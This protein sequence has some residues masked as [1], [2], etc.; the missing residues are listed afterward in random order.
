MSAGYAVI[1]QYMY[2]ACTGRIKSNLHFHFI[3]SLEAFN[4][5]LEAIHQIYVIV[6]YSHTVL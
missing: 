3:V 6:N 1:L 2:T 4:S 5:S